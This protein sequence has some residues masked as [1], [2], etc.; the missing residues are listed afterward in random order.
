M[1]ADASTSARQQESEAIKVYP[2]SQTLAAVMSQRGLG[3]CSRKQRTSSSGSSDV[4]APSGVM[5]RSEPSS[6]P[7]GWQWNGYPALL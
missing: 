4:S 2:G 5:A 7:M 6:P 3:G 1:P